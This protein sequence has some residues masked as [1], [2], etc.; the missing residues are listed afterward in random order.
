[1]ALWIM[2]FGGTVS[3]GNLIAGPIVGAVGITAV[4]LFGAVVA[5]ILFTYA[6]VRTPRL[7]DHG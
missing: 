5:M 2:G 7:S 1:M 4:L 3:L 6:D